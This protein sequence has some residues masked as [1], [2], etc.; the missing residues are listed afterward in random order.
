MLNFDFVHTY[1][2]LTVLP[3]YLITFWVD[4]KLI[5][6]NVYAVEPIAR[7]HNV[8]LFAPEALDV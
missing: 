6:A 3:A 7:S 5:P 2:Y 4:S 8:K 1:L